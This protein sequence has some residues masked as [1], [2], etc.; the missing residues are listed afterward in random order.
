MELFSFIAATIR[1]G[2]PILFAG[3][4]CLF[5]A[6]SGIINIGTEGTMLFGSL[7]GVL[8]SYLFHSSL[9]G[10]MTA[11][12]V[13]GIVGFLFA[14][15]V[16][17]VGANQI[18]MGMGINLLA[19]GLTAVIF[20][21]VFGILTIPCEIKSFNILK[22]PYL[23]KIPGLGIALFEHTIFVY[24]AYI[25]VP[26]ASWILFKTVIGL[27]IRAVGEVPGAAD[28]VGINVFKLRY[29]T[30][31]IGSMLVGLGGACLSIADLRMFTENMTAGKGYMALA[32]VIFGRWRPWGVLIAAL[33]F[34]A[35]EALQ[36]RLQ[37]QDSRI[38]YQLLAMIPYIFTV[39]VLTSFA[40]STLQ[41]AATGKAYKRE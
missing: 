3:L 1:I 34:G 22:I 37:I 35:G 33:F 28:T 40:K 27:R 7:A 6:R 36:L 38:P 8:G 12:V 24:V 11:I 9:L 21:L 32:A 20:R 15:L 14:Y 26:I 17:T 31:I 10:S 18:V 16:V 5:M 19:L 25:L 39:L 30:C 29:I 13:G 41:P 4:G 23:H 2:T